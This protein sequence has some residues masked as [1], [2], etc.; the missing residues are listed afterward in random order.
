MNISVW[1]ICFLRVVVIMNVTVFVQILSDQL[2]SFPNMFRVMIHERS[3]CM[4][5]MGNFGDCDF[6]TM[7]ER[8]G[9]GMDTS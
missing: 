4:C 8:H 5:W 9:A 6:Y 7:K 2:Y 1:F 3:I